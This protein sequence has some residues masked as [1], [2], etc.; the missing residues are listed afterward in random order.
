[1]GVNVRDTLLDPDADGA[2]DYRCMFGDSC[3]L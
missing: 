1:M 3:V 2:A